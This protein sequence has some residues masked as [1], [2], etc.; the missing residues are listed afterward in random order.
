MQQRVPKV[1]CWQEFLRREFQEEHGDDYQC[2]HQ[3]R[4]EYIFI[5]IDSS[6]HPVMLPCDR[7]H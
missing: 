7:S 3:N 5:H 1:I 4:F 2:N 6:D